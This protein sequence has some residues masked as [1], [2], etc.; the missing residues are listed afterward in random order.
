[1]S[2][3][4]RESLLQVMPCTV[5]PIPWSVHYHLKELS[6]QVAAVPLACKAIVVHLDIYFA[7][8]KL[9]MYFSGTKRTPKP[10]VHTVRSSH[11]MY[12]PLEAFSCGFHLQ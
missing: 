6:G 2:P 11:C 3:E 8:F 5:F 1:M 10:L 12:W 9:E 4:V 7:G